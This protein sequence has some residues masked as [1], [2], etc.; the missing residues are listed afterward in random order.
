MPVCPKCSTD[1]PSRYNFCGVCGTPLGRR[2]PNCGE[3]VP[4]GFQFCGVCGT[5][6]E[7]GQPQPSGP[8]PQVAQPTAERR[9][10]SVLFADLVGFTTLSESRDA[11]EVRELLTRYFDTCRRLIELYGGTIEKFIGDAV[12][13][14]WGTPIAKEDDAERAVR[15][16]LELTEAVAALGAQVGAPELRARAGV[17]TGEAAVTVGAEG[18]GMVAGDLVNT[19]SRIQSAAQPGEVFVGDA[20]RRATEASIAYEDA[21]E[22]ALKGK[23]EP[24]QLWR[25]ARVV[26][27]IRGALKSQGLEAPF[28]GRDRELRLIKDLFHAT[29]DESKAHLVSVTGI[30]GIGKSRTM[31]EFFKYIDGVATA[32]R[33]HRGRCLAYG[34]GVT[35]WALAEM[36]RTR[37]G[38]V[39]AEEQSSAMAKLRQALEESVPDPE[40]RRFLEP[41][42]AHLIGLEERSARDRE[43]LFSAWRLFYERL[44]EEM[45]TIMVFEDVQWADASLLD[46]IEYLLDWSRNHRIFILT[47]GR[48]EIATKRPNWGGNKRGMTTLYLESLSHQA[49]VELMDGFVP[50]LPEEARDR[51]LARAEGVPLYAVETV[52]MLLDRGLL[53]REGNA[54]RLSGPIDSLEVPET[55]HALIAARLDGLAPDERRA[56]QDASVL[57]KTFTPASL[58]AL[59]GISEPGLE[60]LLAALVRKEVLHVQADVLSPERGQ[61]GFVQD[62]VRQVAYDTLS[63]K[64]RKLRHLAVAAYLVDRWGEEE[65]EI[66]EVVASHYLQAYRSAPSAED[67]DEIKGKARAML[68]RA[69]ER[70]ASLAASEEAQHYYEQA[71]ELTEDGLENAELYE[72]A[73]M[74]ATNVGRI[75]EALNLLERAVD[76]FTASGQPRPA[77]RVGASIAGLWWSQG[78]AVKAVERLEQSYD[79]LSQ[80]E[81]DATLAW[82]ASQLGR[83]LAISDEWREAD[84][85]NEVAL[86]LAETL[87][88]PEVLSHALNT[89]GMILQRRNRFIEARLLL[90]KAL[91]VALENN[92]SKAA[93]R[94]FNN[95][96]VILECLDAFAEEMQMGQEALDFARRVG[97]RPSEWATLTSYITGLVLLGHWDQ[98]LDWASQARESGAELGP[99]WSMMNLL[100]L[101]WIHAARGELDKAHELLRSFEAMRHAEDPQRQVIF[102]LDEAI[103]LAAEGR[104]K[105]ALEAV[106]RVFPA[107]V[108]LGSTSSNLKLAL[109]AALEAATAL[110]DDK[111]IEELLGFIEHLRPGEITPFLRAIGARFGAHLA[112]LRGDAETP[113]GSFTTAESILRDLQLRFLL[114]VT[115]V[116]HA[117]WLL[118]RDRAND[119]QPLLSEAGDFFEEVRAT[120][121]IERVQRARARAG[122]PVTA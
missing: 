99:Q 113:S 63:K 67:A 51:I 25:A 9:I 120:P 109:Q 107:A 28:V 6:M 100:D 97:D 98:A 90:D 102:V 122:T 74:M 86:E 82:V 62:L 88:L 104:H 83:F 59:S 73:G 78:H 42:L 44:S 32:F 17:L 87:G 76:L 80:E 112:A 35:Y 103:V 8:S 16:A 115:Q 20:T 11:E 106:T 108:G 121:S 79:V 118:D 2:C 93:L 47:L 96:G 33:W 58:A 22:H 75:D 43:D 66:V 56:V 54:Y 49:M 55:L 27:G 50:G 13:A 38:I 60:P 77:A 105:E 48:P 61:Y 52:R 3:E 119:A 92:L 45:P 7:D 36:V 53:V 114:A 91:Q 26:S 69:A 72:Q 37:A 94:A 110:R 65:E 14:V 64:D 101:T 1:N 31:W 46:F 4:A 68:K 41:R 84:G 39:E 12:M 89:R 111:K 23:T 29:V 5:S 71:A 18:Q 10:V 30:A 85:P 15:T 21:G 57:G 40:E 70:A 24:L 19:A 34:E 95:L 117:E 81:P 116:E